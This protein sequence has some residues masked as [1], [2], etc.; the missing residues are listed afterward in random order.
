MS[1][2]ITSSFSQL[3]Y[4]AYGVPG[5]YALYYKGELIYVGSGRDVLEALKHQKAKFYPSREWGELDVRDFAIKLRREKFCGEFLSGAAR[6]VSKLQP[7]H[8]PRSPSWKALLQQIKLPLRAL[9]AGE[10][11]EPT[12]R[13]YEVY[14]IP[15]ANHK[16]T[17]VL[18]LDGLVLEKKRRLKNNPW[19]SRSLVRSPQK[20]KHRKSPQTTKTKGY[21]RK[22]PIG[23]KRQ[24][25]FG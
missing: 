7:N 10:L 13:G 14:S 21:I 6:L 11:P 2:W 22:L 4:I 16:K 8:N 25:V 24:E 15:G 23:H 19:P 18:T 1:R 12:G 9:S 20:R 3:N 5:V 17:W